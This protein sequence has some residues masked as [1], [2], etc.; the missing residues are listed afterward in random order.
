MSNSSVIWQKLNLSQACG[1]L[2]AFF[3][4]LTGVTVGLLTYQHQLQQGEH[5][6]REHIRLQLQRL[7]LT[8]APSILNEDR[9]SLNLTLNEWQLD[10]SVPAVRIL[11]NDQQVVAETGRMS[12]ARDIMTQAI[13]QDDL[14]VGMLQASIDLSAVSAA[15]RRYLAISL[16]VSSLLA[17]L[18][19]WLAYYLCER[20]LRFIRELSTR[21][22]RWQHGDQ[23]TLTVPHIPDFRALYQVLEQMSAAEQQRRSLEQALDQFISN[24]PLHDP[25]DKFRYHNCALLYIEIQE[26][27]ILQ[28]R[29]SATELSQLL[30]QYHSL[31]SQ[32][33][34]LYNG[35]LDRFQGDGIVMLFG[36]P[37]SDSQDALHSLYAAMLFLGLV[38]H[39]REHDSRLL[40]LEFRIAAHF[41][42]VL[43]A[44]IHD[45]QNIQGNLIGDT[46]H[47]A[48]QLAQSGE[49]RRLLASQAIIDQIGNHNDIH[50]QDGPAISDLSGNE[51]LS[52]WLNQLPEKNQSLIARQIKHITAM[53]EQA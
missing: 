31:L 39:L 5:N 17:L 16:F 37:S 47:W 4:L 32:A 34:K 50:W 19:A 11:N 13:T 49:E 35:K 7:A 23:L 26:L 14:A 42:P 20:V 40:P 10:A 6:G 41:G 46:I 29:L 12:R 2:A 33:A 30:N 28:S 3:I 36:L 22:Q 52:Y 8:L 25:A 15:A 43:L 44:P 1:L 21:L 9:V 24:E 38:D 53:T 18:G 51:Q 48:S 27:E 45:G